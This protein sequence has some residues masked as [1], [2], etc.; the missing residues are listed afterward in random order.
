[1]A[2]NWLLQWGH[3]LSAMETHDDADHQRHDDHPSMG[4]PP[5]GDGNAIHDR[6]L[7]PPGCPSMGPPPFGDGNAVGGHLSA[8]RYLPGFNG[9]TA[10]RRWKRCRP[11]RYALESWGFNGATAFRRWKQ[12]MD[13]TRGISECMLQWGHRLSAMETVDWIGPQLGVRQAS[14]GPPPFGDG[15]GVSRVTGETGGRCFNGATAFRRWKLESGKGW[16][17]HA[18]VLQWGHRLSA[19][20]TARKEGQT[21]GRLRA[22]MGPPPFGDGNVAPQAH[23]NMRLVNA[24]MGPPPFGDGNQHLVDIAR[25][26]GGAS[27]GPPPFGDG[28]IK[29]LFYQLDGRMCFNGATAFR[30]WKPW[31]AAPD[32]A[33]SPPQDRPPPT[34]AGCGGSLS[35]SPTPQDTRRGGG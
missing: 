9:A 6:E 23:E 27:M 3:R 14:M 19:M 5:F 7:H 22:S 21:H 18:P 24:S 8:Y 29:F 1:M 35:P 31:T 26:Q 15:N 10:F 28:N 32:P 17:L 20:E 16:H 13:Q 34:P 30:R 12:G 25:F 2:Q 33:R 4:P 11:G